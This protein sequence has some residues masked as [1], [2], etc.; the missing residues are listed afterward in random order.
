MLFNSF[1]FAAF[2]PVVFTLYWCMPFKYRWTVILAS[3]CFFY[4]CW[5]IRYLLILFAT[6]VIS[7]FAAIKIEDAGNARVKKIT[8]AVGIVLC[9]CVLFF[10]KYFNF[11]L[12]SISALLKMLSL[13][14][15]D[16][17]LSLLLPVGISF[18]IF[19]MVG[20]LVDVYRKTIPAEHHFGYY[21]AYVAFF[22]KL[23]EGPIERAGNLLPQLKT[24]HAFDY[25]LA[26]Y[27]LKQMAWGFFKKLLIADILATY[28]NAVFASPKSFSGFALVLASLFYTVQIYCDFSGYS[29]IAIGCA[30][31][32]GIELTTNFKSPYLSQSIKEFWSRWHISLSTWLRDYVYIPLG[33]N[34]VSK[35]RHAF[36]L[37]A[38]FLISGLWHG[39]SWTFVIWGGIHGIA[40]VL[41]N[42]LIPKDK[43]KSTGFLRWLRV[44]GIFIFS[45]CAWT[46]FASG[47]V[48][49]ACYV[50]SHFFDG[51]AAPSLYFSAGIA[52]IGISALEIAEELFFIALLFVYDFSAL[53]TD[54][55]GRLGK[56]KK[57]IRWTVYVLFVLML[58]F[59]TSKGVAAEFVYFQF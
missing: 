13:K 32:F 59:L 27:G 45:A 54:V 19:Q 49:D 12:E 58:I 22:P 6:T 4:A 50:I 2:L 57:P 11:A 31:L 1:S 3:G 34:R 17:S 56:L 20:Y 16:V 48:S 36:N 43:M 25:E 29:D 28:A 10:F 44:I 38:T 8:A 30:K 41:E 23:A 55:I 46:F 37:I 33:G 52:D 5:D 51:I 15:S 40:Q 47:S 7:Y 53:K 39:A 21:A 35:A 18:Y 9:L 42:L 24:E 14:T 26:S